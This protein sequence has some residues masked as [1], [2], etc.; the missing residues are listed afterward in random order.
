MYKQPII[1]N[2]LKEQTFHN[3][4]VAKVV[5]TNKLEEKLDKLGVDHDLQLSVFLGLVH[6]EGSARYFRDNHARMAV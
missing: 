5:E 2:F 3:P 4:P 6:G 1:G